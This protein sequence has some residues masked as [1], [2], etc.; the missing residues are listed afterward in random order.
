MLSRG[1][2]V[3][4]GE[5]TAGEATAHR[6][7]HGFNATH[8]ASRWFNMGKSSLKSSTRE[9]LPKVAPRHQAWPMGNTGTS[10]PASVSYRSPRGALMWRYHPG[11]SSSHSSRPF[12]RCFHLWAARPTQ[13]VPAHCQRARCQEGT[14]PPRLRPQRQWRRRRRRHVRQR[15]RHARAVQT[16]RMLQ[17][18]EIRPPSKCAARRHAEHQPWLIQQRILDTIGS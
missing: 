3:T 8:A 17:L 11:G 15:R 4:A 18:V 13:Q 6:G 7:A 1:R 9:Y 2:A 5:A 10:Q 16:L 12:A 14:H